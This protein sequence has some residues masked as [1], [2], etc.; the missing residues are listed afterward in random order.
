M[1]GKLHIPGFGPGTRGYG[2]APRRGPGAVPEQPAPFRLASRSDQPPVP[3]SGPALGSWP[4]AR[5]WL[6]APGG[7]WAPGF[8]RAL[9]SG[10]WARS[11]LRALGSLRARGSR[12]FAGPRSL[13]AVRSLPWPVQPEPPVSKCTPCVQPRTLFRPGGAEQGF[14]GATVGPGPAVQV[15]QLVLG[16]ESARRDDLD[17][18]LV[19]VGSLGLAEIRRF[20]GSNQRLQHWLARTAADI[21]LD[22]AAA[23]GA[24]PVIRRAA[25]SRGAGIGSNRSQR[26]RP[27]WH[28]RCR[29][30]AADEAPF[31]H[32]RELVA[33]EAPRGGCAPPR[34]QQRRE[35][36][37]RA[38][39]CLAIV[40]GSEKAARDVDGGFAPELAIAFEQGTERQP[41]G[42]TEEPGGVVVLVAVGGGHPDGDIESVATPP[43]AAAR[44][45]RQGHSEPAD[46]CSTNSTRRAR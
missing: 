43:E 41:F 4:W 5:S 6:Q 10:P 36:V 7:L 3:G 40:T 20:S 42:M 27:P 24:E 8:G 34:P 31:L 22:I 19:V 11:W 12:H 32:D 29:Q 25:P 9:G 23:R 30:A 15:A 21:E 26:E 17:D 44:R 45:W 37:R 1:C 13:S 38:A 46:L 16:E 28:R 35:A 39:A 2:S 33:A 14:R 18:E